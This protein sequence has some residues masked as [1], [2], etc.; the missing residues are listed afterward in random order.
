MMGPQHALTG[1]AAWSCLI[2]VHPPAVPVLVAGYAVTAGAALWPDLDHPDATAARSL[3]P[4]SWAVAK[5]VQAL[6]GG[7]RRGTHSLV[8]C[9]AVGVLC[10]TAVHAR[11]A[12]WA[13]VALTVVLAVMLASLAHVVPIRSWRRSSADEL[14]ALLAAV[15]ISWWPGLDLDALAPA[16]LIGTLA[17]L[18]GD[19]IT[20][21]GIPLFWP[22]SRECI[23]VA[24]LKAGGPTERYLIRWVLVAAIPV[25]P[26]W[27][28][29]S[30]AL[31]AR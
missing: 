26:L 5:V 14:L 22:F 11:P 27:E 31:A 23:R 3:G 28:P 30:L 9:A 7:H 19:I 10:A 20:R 1:A 18:A 15:G 13:S 6:S 29:V 25:V 12:I 2:A 17:H 21:Q 4:L 8:G 16:V 24:R